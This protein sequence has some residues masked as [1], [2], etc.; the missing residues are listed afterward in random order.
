MQPEYIAEIRKAVTD[1]TER[2]LYVAA[3]WAAEFLASP[4]APL[5]KPAQVGIASRLK[6]TKDDQVVTQNQHQ[7]IR[8]ERD[9]LEEHECD[10]HSVGRAYFDA[11]EFERAAHVLKDCRSSRSRFLAVYSHYLV[12]TPPRRVNIT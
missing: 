4:T 8:D 10:V 3:R 9:P 6:P 2:G 11:K 7:D 1:C 5:P 12:R